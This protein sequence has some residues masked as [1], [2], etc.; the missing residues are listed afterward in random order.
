M[1][2]KRGF[3]NT[4]DYIKKKQQIW[5]I[6]NNISLMGSEGERGEHNYTRSLVENLY[7]PLSEK[8]IEEFNKADGNEFKSKKMNALHSSSAIVVNVVEFLKSSNQLDILAKAL[9][10]P[11]TNIKNIS[12]EEK[13][14]IFPD[15]IPPNIDLCF[16]YGN[17]ITAIESK[18][19]EPYQAR[20]HPSLKEK[21]LKDFTMWGQIPNIHR[22]AEDIFKANK[23]FQYLDVAQLIKHVL[24]LL[25][26]DPENNKK[27]RLVYLWYNAFGED[28]FKHSCE[29]SELSSIFN[30]DVKFQSITW[31]EVI[32]K[33]FHSDIK[34]GSNNN[35]L[36]YKNYIT[37]RYL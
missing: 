29:I 7:M 19:T 31:Q 25:S 15:N 12:Y 27:F 10:I 21:Y 30:E 17:S 22:L 28:G 16:N 20:E 8:S 34:D 1:F 5:G 24:G 23:E 14:R 9:K 13:F 37:E 35:A 18:F 36:D 33:L 3:M 4:F 32:I 11:S 26:Y 6:I 2:K